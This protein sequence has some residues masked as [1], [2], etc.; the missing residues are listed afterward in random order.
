M[1]YRLWA[2]FW[3]NSLLKNTDL[4]ELHQ[5][6]DELM[7][8]SFKT[9]QIKNVNIAWLLQQIAL[10]FVQYRVWNLNDKDG[11]KLNIDESEQFCV[12]FRKKCKENISKQILVRGATDKLQK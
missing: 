6:H 1:G 8:S 9:Y 2:K 11:H 7:A 10:Q 4:R 3:L 5:S 12:V